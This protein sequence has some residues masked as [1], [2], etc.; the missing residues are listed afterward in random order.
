MLRVGMRDCLRVEGPAV[1]P[2]SLGRREDTRHRH[3]TVSEVPG[4][5]DTAALTL[6]IA[7]VP[8]EVEGGNTIRW[9]AGSKVALSP[10]F[11]HTVGVFPA[12]HSW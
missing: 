5:K 1:V 4:R 9:V 12:M 7:L 6:R 2:A 8:S 3:S 11:N 10:V